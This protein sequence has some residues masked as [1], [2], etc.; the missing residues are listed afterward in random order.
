MKAERGIVLSDK[1][2][3]EVLLNWVGYFDLL[4]KIYHRD[5]TQ[6]SQSTS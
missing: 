6:K 3:K 1:E 5:Q 2:A 4:S